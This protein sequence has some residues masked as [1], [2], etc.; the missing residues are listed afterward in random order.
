[1]KA[2]YKQQDISGKYRFLD[3]FARHKGAWKA[4]ATQLTAVASGK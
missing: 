4:V 2:T 3:V 1:M